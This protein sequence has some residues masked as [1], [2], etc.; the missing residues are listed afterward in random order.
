MDLGL[1]GKVALVF[2]ASDGLGLAAAK[3]LHAEGARVMLAARTESKLKSVTDQ[4]KGSG[5]VV[6]DT[7]I[8]G[9]A[10]QAVVSTISKFGSVDVLVT[11]TGGPPK[12]LFEELRAEDWLAGFQNLWVS[13]VD[14]IRAA[15]PGMRERHFGRILMVTSAAARQPI[16]GLTISNGLRAGISGLVRSLAQEVASSGVTVNAVLPGYT[17]TDRLKEL[18]VSL[19]QIVGDIPAKRLARPEEFGALVAFLASQHAGYITGQSIACDGG[20]I[21]GL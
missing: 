13:A 4:L 10:A 3:Q 11:N 20:W 18:K 15:L 8:P 16:R 6:C 1:N 17:D 19:E 9:S 14:G 5:F 21:R 2:G 7:G 12:G